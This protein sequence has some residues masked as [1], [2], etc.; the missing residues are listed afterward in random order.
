MSSQSHKLSLSAVLV[1]AMLTSMP[2]QAVVSGELSPAEKQQL[3]ESMTPEAQYRLSQ[4][5]AYAAYDEARKACRQAGASERTTC[6]QAA[7]SQLR[8]DLEYAK[9]SLQAGRSSTVGTGASSSMTA[10]TSAK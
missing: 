8:D 2:V 10:S 3:V 1:A 9:S 7:K 5:E 6:M 4:R